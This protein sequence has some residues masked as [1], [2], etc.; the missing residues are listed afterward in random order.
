M[1][2]LAGIHNEPI[3]V[4]PRNYLKQKEHAENYYTQQPREEYEEVEYDD[5]DEYEYYE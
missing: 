2:E 5:D 4:K 1:A 3:K